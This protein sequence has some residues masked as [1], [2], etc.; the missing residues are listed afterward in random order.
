M[1][2]GRHERARC[3]AVSQSPQLI[4]LSLR[5]LSLVAVFPEGRRQSFLLQTHHLQ[6]SIFIGPI[7]DRVEL[8][9][10]CSDR[11]YGGYLELTKERL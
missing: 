10:L 5:V 4:A 8:L 3:K 1:K 6:A 9:D 11:F 2:T 7:E